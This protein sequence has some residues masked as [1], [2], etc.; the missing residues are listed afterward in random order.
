M[1]SSSHDEAASNFVRSL[2]K[3]GLAPPHGTEHVNYYTPHNDPFYSV[4]KYSPLDK[5]R[6]YI[7]LLK[8]FPKK[9]TLKDHLVDHP[10]WKTSADGPAL[11]GFSLDI[12]KSS[13]SD[14]GPELLACMVIDGVPL[15]RCTGQYLALSYAAGDPEKTAQ[16]LVDGVI[17]NAFAQ[18][19]HA[20]ECAVQYYT[21][22]N[23]SQDGFCLFWVDQICINQSDPEERGDQVKIMRDIYS[24]SVTTLVCLL[25]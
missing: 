4:Y 16:I 13:E 24:R 3:L 25:G 22:K 18:L 5:K 7:R 6:R 10:R 2:S 9:K 19:V 21:R 11:S 20:L 14:S 23:T 1:A 12:S 17:F 15:A 8:V